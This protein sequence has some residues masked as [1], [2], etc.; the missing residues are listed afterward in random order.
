MLRVDH[1]AE[2]RSAK[3][4]G[5]SIRAIARMLHHS[6]RK[7]RAVLMHPEPTPCTRTNP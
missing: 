2:I 4:D 7:V 3:R 5:L 6:R 1:Y